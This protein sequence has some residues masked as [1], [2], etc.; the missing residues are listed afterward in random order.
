M[1]HQSQE[2]HRDFNLRAPSGSWASVNGIIGFQLL[3]EPNWDRSRCVIHTLD[4]RLTYR[5]SN[6]F[7]EVD[8]GSLKIKCGYLFSVET[9]YSDRDNSCVELSWLD[10]EIPTSGFEPTV[11]LDSTTDLLVPAIALHILIAGWHSSYI[12][13]IQSG[14]EHGLILRHVG[15]AMFTR[16]GAYQQRVGMH[17]D[18]APLEWPTEDQEI[19]TIV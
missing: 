1:W 13:S 3:D 9:K 10:R 8:G 4:V 7:G 15:E 12:G 14:T 19:I 2:H 17:R 5:S 16:I 18:R 6:E 11:Y